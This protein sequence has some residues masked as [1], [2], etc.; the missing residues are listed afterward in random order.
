MDRSARPH[1]F[2]AV[3]KPRDLPLVVAIERRSFS[4]PWSLETFRSE[5]SQSYSLLLLAWAETPRSPELAGY[6]CRWI[7]D[8]EVQ[9]LNVAVHPDWRRRGV[10]RWIVEEVLREARRRHVTRAT[11]EVRR[12]NLPAIVLYERLGFERVGV[13]RNYYGPGE[14]AVLMDKILIA[15]DG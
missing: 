6:V 7:V 8:R 11:L 2:L 1:L 5:T 12:H 13:R 14:D 10:G 15:D 3:A 9:I 4:H